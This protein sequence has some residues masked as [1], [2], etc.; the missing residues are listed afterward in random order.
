[1]VGLKRDYF[2]P[3]TAALSVA[4][5]LNAGALEA[6]IL[7]SV[8]VA[9]LRPI[10]AARLRTSNVPKPIRATLSPF[11]RVAVTISINVAMLRS[12]SILVLPVLSASAS[13]SSLRFMCISSCCCGRSAA[14]DCCGYWAGMQGLVDGVIS[15]VAND[16]CQHTTLFQLEYAAQAYSWELPPSA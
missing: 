4:P 13:I 15:R 1:M 12:A 3:F 6:L 5:A 11:L 9:G 8:P 10:R 2:P 7:S 16:A 14:A